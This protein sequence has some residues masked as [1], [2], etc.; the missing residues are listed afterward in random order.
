MP[1]ENSSKPRRLIGP[2]GQPLTLGNLPPA[3]TKRWTMR[4][5]AEVILAV[6]GGLITANNVCERYRMSIE[7]LLSWERLIDRHGL[8]GLLVTRRQEYR[9]A[10]QVNDN[11]TTSSGLRSERVATDKTPQRT[12]RDDAPAPSTRRDDWEVKNAHTPGR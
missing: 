11:G 4:R 3:D 10:A 2:D 7:E 6:Q 1:H 9:R 5:K 8:R 12:M